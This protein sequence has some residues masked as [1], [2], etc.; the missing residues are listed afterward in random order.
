MKLYLIP[1]ALS[2]ENIETIPLYVSPAVR[3]IRHFL[4]EE[5]KSA[6]RF[7]KKIVPDL[8]IQECELF[9]LSEHTREDELNEY[10]AKWKGKDI[11]ILSEAGCPCVADPGADVVLW[12]HENNVEVIPLVG[13]SSIM[14][15]LM[16]S[17]LNGQSFAF[18]G[19]LPKDKTERIK[20]LKTLE[21]KS[22]RDHQT[23]MFMETPYRNDALLQD[24]LENGRPETMLCLAADLTLPEQW[25]KT[26]TI[27]E[28]RRSKIP[29]LNKRPALFLIQACNA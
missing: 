10:L 26:M 24:I 1:T 15:A 12:A 25:I 28:W 20:K 8:P 6:R 3:H 9:N 18:H 17:G 29:S 2:P 14:L 16:A 22:E 7:L 27:G 19:Y 11:G 23:Q 5:E 13:P 4:V 21:Q